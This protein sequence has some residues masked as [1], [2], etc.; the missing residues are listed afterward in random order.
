MELLES[1]M[2]EIQPRLLGQLRENPMRYLGIAREL[3]GVGAHEK[4]LEL[5]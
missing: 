3:M 4:K 1:E 5:V 2:R